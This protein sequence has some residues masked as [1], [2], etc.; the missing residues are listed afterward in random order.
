MLDAGLKVFGA[1]AYEALILDELCV[2]ADVSRL[3]LQ[4]YF[5]SKKVSSWRSSSMALRWLRLW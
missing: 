5:G 3:L 4:H 2:A 1:K